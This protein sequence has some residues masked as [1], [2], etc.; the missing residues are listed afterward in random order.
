M[1]KTFTGAGHLGI[2]PLPLNATTEEMNLRADRCVIALR[3]KLV[4]ENP[5]WEF[6]KWAGTD[7]P[8]LATPKK[9]VLKPSP[10]TALGRALVERW[11]PEWHNF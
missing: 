10:P 7:Y 9:G 5:D 6:T 4:K 2:E 8:F 1:G 11:E 3:E